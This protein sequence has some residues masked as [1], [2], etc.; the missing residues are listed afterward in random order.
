MRGEGRGRGRGRRRRRRSQEE[1]EEKEHKKVRLESTLSV[2]G[3]MEPW[4]EQLSN[5]SLHSNRNDVI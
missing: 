1:E 5:K 3:I 2:K 4:K